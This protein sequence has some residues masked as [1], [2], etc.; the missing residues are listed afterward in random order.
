MSRVWSK[1]E[2]ILNYVILSLSNI[3]ILA[4]LEMLVRRVNFN[5]LLER[6]A[7]ADID[8]ACALVELASPASPASPICRAPLNLAVLCVHHSILI[9]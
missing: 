1:A 5:V 9:L 3:P 4:R 8:L 7:P 6:P 2:H